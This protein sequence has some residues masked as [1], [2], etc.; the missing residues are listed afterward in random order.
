MSVLWWLHFHCLLKLQGFNSHVL[1]IFSGYFHGKLRCLC[2]VWVFCASKSVA[3]VSV[4]TLRNTSSGS[5]LWSPPQLS[6]HTIPLLALSDKKNSSLVLFTSFASVAGAFFINIL[7]ENGNIFMP[8]D[9][10]PGTDVNG[11]PQRLKCPRI[12]ILVKS[13][14]GTVTHSLRG[15]FRK[16]WRS[17][18]KNCKENSALCTMVILSWKVSRVSDSYNKI[19][20][21]WE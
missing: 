11:L 16:G 4:D 2:L 14:D 10:S 17:L 6:R 7:N 13:H 20:I 5:A 3:V 18:S 21:V 9:A 8:P 19:Y 1:K 12:L 15:S